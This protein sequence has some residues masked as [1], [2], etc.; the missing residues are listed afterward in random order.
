MK[1]I[2]I[3]FNR[4]AYICIYNYDNDLIFN[5][6]TYNNEIELCLEECNVYKIIATSN[7]QRLVTSFFINNNDIYRFGFNTFNN[8]ITFL[9]TDYYYN[10]PIERGELLLWQRQ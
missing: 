10:L 1:K 6:N 3:K 2:K 8:T 5:G 9:L 7:Y 4:D